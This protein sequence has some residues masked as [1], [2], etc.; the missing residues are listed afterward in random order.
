MEMA[1]VI[2]G[3]GPS[4]G[5]KSRSLILPQ[6]FELLFLISDLLLAWEFHHDVVL[7]TIYSQWG[8]YQV[9]SDICE[10]MGA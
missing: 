2:N 9:S 4:P 7:Q 8:Y 1:G 5:F 3:A 10:S 6:V